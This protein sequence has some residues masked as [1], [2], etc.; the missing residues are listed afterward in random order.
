MANHG[1][2]KRLLFVRGGYVP[3]EPAARLTTSHANCAAGDCGEPT[4]ADRAAPG[5]DA[6]Q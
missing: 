5:P 6:R 1:L 2:R 3:M 4:P